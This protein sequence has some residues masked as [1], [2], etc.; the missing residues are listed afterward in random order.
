MQYVLIIIASALTRQWVPSQY[1][2]IWQRHH[3]QLLQG[4]LLHKNMNI[5]NY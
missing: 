4:L 2:D 3:D 5:L 1:Q